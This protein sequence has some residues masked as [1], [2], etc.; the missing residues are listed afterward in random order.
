MSRLKP[1]VGQWYRDE[2][3]G[4]VFE[5]VAIDHDFIEVQHE[6]GD[7]EEYDLDGWRELV[8]CAVDAPEDWRNG[9]GLSDED[10]MMDDDVVRPDSF[11]ESID[12]IEPDVEIDLDDY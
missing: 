1:V 3:Q 12:G 2:E 11:S 6:D 10:R 4:V 7:I 9:L 8:L 5:I